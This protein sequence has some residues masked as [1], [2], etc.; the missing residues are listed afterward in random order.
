MQIARAADR[1]LGGRR[2]F[3]RWGQI[4]LTWFFTPRPGQLVEGLFGHLKGAHRRRHTSIEH[5]LRDD[6]ADLLLGNANMERALDVT[7]D[8]MGAVAQHCQRR[9]SA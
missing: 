9:D 1:G 6:L 2:R 3:R 8:Q 4:R 7:P 5:H